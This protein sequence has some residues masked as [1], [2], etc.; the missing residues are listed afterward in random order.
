MLLFLNKVYQRLRLREMVLNL[1]VLAPLG[2]FIAMKIH[3]AYHL[4]T[5]RFITVAKLVM[6]QK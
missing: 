1:W 4:F 3:L 2:Q 5:L 6:R